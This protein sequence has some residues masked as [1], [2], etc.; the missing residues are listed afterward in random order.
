LPCTRGEDVLAELKRHPRF[1]D[2][3]VVVFTGTEEPHAVQHCYALGANAFL[4]KPMDV[5][6][7]YA[8]VRTRVEFWR[9][10]Q[11]PRLAPVPEGWG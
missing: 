11:V 2:I 4:R 7:D 1:K 6:E 3:P 5:D 9:T 10:C 8:L